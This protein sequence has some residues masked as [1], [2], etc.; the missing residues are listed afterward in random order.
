MRTLTDSYRQ[1]GIVINS[2]EARTA[3]SAVSESERIVAITIWT[4]ELQRDPDTGI[5][6][7]DTREM[8]EG[9]RGA[10]R[11]RTGHKNRLRHLQYAMD[12]GGT[13]RVVKVRPQ[14]GESHEERHAQMTDSAPWLY[15]GRP[16]EAHVVFFD[17]EDFRVEI[18]PRKIIE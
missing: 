17:G 9:R 11:Q 13:V 1:L 3:W 10:W 12:W 4:D 5:Y 18:D 6:F 2:G 8:D 14:L 7:L 15:Q 16:I